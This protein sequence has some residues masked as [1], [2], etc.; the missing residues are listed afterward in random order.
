MLLHAKVVPMIAL[1]WAGLLLLMCGMV[2]RLFA[3]DDPG[4][5]HGSAG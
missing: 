1:L 4:H 5:A 2:V 3:F